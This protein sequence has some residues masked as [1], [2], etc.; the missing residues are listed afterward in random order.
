MY[1]Y[2]LHVKSS[3]RSKY[4]I[5]IVT[6]L[7]IYTT[8]VEKG[9]GDDERD[10]VVTMVMKRQAVGADRTRRPYRRA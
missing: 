3:Y 5:T 2:I 8:R 6:T 4:R 1:T 10:A 9:C 7:A